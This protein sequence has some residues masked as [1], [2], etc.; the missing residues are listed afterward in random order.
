MSALDRFYCTHLSKVQIPNY[1]EYAQCFFF[2]PI[3]INQMPSLD[4]FGI[5]EDNNL[6]INVI[7]NKK[8]HTFVTA[9]MLQYDFGINEEDII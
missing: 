7:I 6:F 4:C 1:L 8:T 3:R 5:L 9:L 2:E